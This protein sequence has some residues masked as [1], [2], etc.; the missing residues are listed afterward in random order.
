MALELKT[1]SME[2]D[3]D[4]KTT[5]FEEKPVEIKIEE[6]QQNVEKIDLDVKQEHSYLP[7]A[8]NIACNEDKKESDTQ[9]TQFFQEHPLPPLDNNST[10][11]PT[12]TEPL[13]DAPQERTPDMKAKK[14]DRI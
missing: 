2:L 11:I 6:T 14:V 9:E 1:E 4:H 12:D 8:M 13:S 5:F 7:T 3:T 10:S